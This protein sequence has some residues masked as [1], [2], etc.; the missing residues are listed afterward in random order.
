[1]A[2]QWKL[3]HNSYSFLMDFGFCAFGLPSVW[4]ANITACQFL[5]LSSVKAGGRGWLWHFAGA[6]LVYL[7]SLW[8]GFGA[9]PVEGEFQT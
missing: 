5:H 3:S 7:K 8:L 9:R 6:L 1:M 2:D 4:F